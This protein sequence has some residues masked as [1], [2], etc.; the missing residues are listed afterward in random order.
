VVPP[1]GA[2]AKLI[3]DTNAGIVVAPDDVEGMTRSL[4]ELHGRW[5]AGSLTEPPL[6]Q[7][8]RDRVSRR[9]RVEELAR[10]LETLA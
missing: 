2:A 7:A 4:R 10:L 5:Q 1:D 8:W 6:S 9:T 3:R